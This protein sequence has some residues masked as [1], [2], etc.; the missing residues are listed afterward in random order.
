M[1]AT[2][3]IFFWVFSDYSL[4]MSKHGSQC[5]PTVSGAK[6]SS[7]RNKNHRT[8]EIDERNNAAFIPDPDYSGDSDVSDS[9][10]EI[11]SDESIFLTCFRQHHPAPKSEVRA[12]AE[13]AKA[14]VTVRANRSEVRDIHIHIYRATTGHESQV[15]RVW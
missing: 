7:I 2:C 1:P 6:K 15:R 14:A 8:V 10:P 3:T 4:V 12:A 11:N 9:N 5:A 13:N